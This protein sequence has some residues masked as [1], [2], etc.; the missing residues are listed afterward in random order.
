MTQM[1][2]T[3]WP[4]QPYPLGA[5]WDGKGVNFAL[6][7]ANAER[8]ELCLFDPKG[9]LETH[10]IVLPEY[11]DQV[12][13][14]YL[15]EARPG[16]LY[17]YRVYGPYNP[18]AGHRF[19][20][21]KLC[22]DPYAKLL[23]GPLKWSDAHFGYIAQ[24]TRK[25]LSYDR[26]DSAFA[27]PK[28]MVVDSSGVSNDRASHL[29]SWK[30]TV[31]Y[32]TH[33][34]GLTMR[35]EGLPE[36]LR[37][38][39]AGLSHPKVIEYLKSLGITSVELLPVH[40]FADDR[41]LVNKGLRNYWGYSTLNFFAPESRYLYQGGI[42]D[43][44][45]MVMRLHDAGIEVILD[46]VFN[47]T[48]EG[49]ETGPTLSFRGIDNASY[50]RLHPDNPRYYIN[51]TGCGNTLNLNHPRV[52]QMVM[53]SLRYWVTHMHVDGFRFDLA[54]TLGREA[55]G[56]DKGSGFFD[57]VGQDPVLSRV[58]LIA[59]PWDLGPGGYQLGGFPCGWSEWNDRM[60]DANRR[61]WRGDAGFM[62][63]LSR[64]LHG[65]GDKFEHSGRHTWA[66]INYVC[67][68]DGFSLRDLVS[69]QQK[70]NLANGENNRDGHSN[71]HSHN[72][73]VEGPTENAEVMEIR[74]RQTRNMLATVFLS[75]GAPMLWMGDERGRT[76]GG[77]NNPYCQDNEISWM[78]WEPLNAF[79]RDHLDFVRRLIRLRKEH[80]VLRRDHFLHG[81]HKSPT[82]GFSDVEWFAPN[83]SHMNSADW[84]DEAACCFGMLLAGDAHPPHRKP[85]D[86]ETLLIVLNAN[87][88][89]KS[90]RVPKARS[91]ISWRCLLDTFN[92]KHPPGGINVMG[93]DHFEAEARSLYVFSLQPTNPIHQTALR[94]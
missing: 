86:Q 76:Q 4:G 56:F 72:Y 82:T 85:D 59:E 12:W 11:T 39:F 15:P 83:G 17:G 70:H 13:H 53:D 51:D 38:T 81:K 5:N 73:G 1:D 84:G 93:G 49:D 58:K 25:D 36:P 9:R 32:E 64:R 79:D 90:F 16:Q 89:A 92:P 27:T 34:R 62:P 19:N 43:F 35:H 94:S 74:L 88:Q 52:L 57:A 33:V 71:D 78:N 24:S 40:A 23:Y 67:S 37:G 14:C 55:H 26:R 21:N 2:F 31:I 50:Y 75:Q 30:D 69:Y 28:S 44:R 66:S 61:F 18:D 91:A 54:T 42:D 20:P 41:F 87:T 65:S 3:V 8:V 48:C 10:R 68:H 22:I 45:T 60:R 77:N 80:P 7:S 6:F 46:V 63:E 29:V 47:H